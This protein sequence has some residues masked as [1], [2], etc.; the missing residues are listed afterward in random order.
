MRRWIFILE[1]IWP[2]VVMLAVTLLL[3]GHIPE[4]IPI[5]FNFYGEP[6]AWSSRSSLMVLPLI[7]AFVSFIAG[8]AISKW[9]RENGGDRGMARN[10]ARAVGCLFLA[11]YIKVLAGGWWEHIGFAFFMIFLGRFFSLKGQNVG[12]MGRNLFYSGIALLVVTPWF[13]QSP[14]S[15]SVLIL[16]LLVGAGYALRNPVANP[17][18]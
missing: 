2:L 5:H 11:L 8:F 12:F 9:E 17:G 14:V 3:W 15:L 1:F 16:N 7:F 6:D 4:Q 13:H 18:R 10:L